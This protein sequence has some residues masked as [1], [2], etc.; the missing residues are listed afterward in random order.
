MRF[1]GEVNVSDNSIQVSN[2]ILQGILTI[3]V[4]IIS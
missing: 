4:Q 2:L 1:G 3:V